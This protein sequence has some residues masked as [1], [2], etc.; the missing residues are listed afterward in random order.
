MEHA[1]E[2][3]FLKAFKKLAVVYY[4]VKNSRLS[5]EFVS[6]IIG[7]RETFVSKFPDPFYEHFNRERVKNIRFHVR[8]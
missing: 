5:R 2:L 3:S 4:Q 1:L 8:R 7:L 6:L